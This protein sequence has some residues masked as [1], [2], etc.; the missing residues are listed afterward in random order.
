MTFSCKQA[1][2]I[3]DE[4]SKTDLLANSDK[5]DI[6]AMYGFLHQEFI[7]SSSLLKEQIS[8]LISNEKLTNDQNAQLYHQLTNEYLEYL[9]YVYSDLINNPKIAKEEFY[10]GEYSKT[11]YINEFFFDGEKY[12]QKASDFISKLEKYRSE[13]LK[14]INHENLAKRVSGELNTDYV[15]NRYAEKY[16]YL[17]YMYKD[18]PLI[19][20]LS[21]MKYRVKIILEFENDFLKNQL[22]NL[23]KNKLKKC[24]INCLVQFTRNLLWKFHWLIHFSKI[25]CSNT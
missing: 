7:Y 25:S 19:S 8:E 16:D 24:I 14:L 15:V 13:I 1:N 20:V 12:N 21:H 18:I 3:N 22:S 9:E 6:Y 23:L 5:T 10:D 4:D 2:E 17:N 11:D